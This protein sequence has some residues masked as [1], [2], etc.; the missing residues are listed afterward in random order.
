V[1]PYRCPGADGRRTRKRYDRERLAMNEHKQ[2]QQQNQDDIPELLLIRR[3]IERYLPAGHRL[4]SIDLTIGSID[5]DQEP[6]FVVLVE[7]AQE[8]R[9][10]EPFGWAH[11][12]AKIIRQKWPRDTFDVKVKIVM[13]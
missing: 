4:N 1:A 10:P 3:I 12:M 8:R 7:L 13:A 9:A 6:R 11:E 2:Q 5:E